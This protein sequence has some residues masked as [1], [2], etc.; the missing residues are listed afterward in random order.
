MDIVKG[1]GNIKGEIGMSILEKLVDFYYVSI[2]GQHKHNYTKL[3]EEGYLPKDQKVGGLPTSWK[4]Y[5]CTD[6][7][8]SI[9]VYDR[10]KKGIPYYN[11]YE[12]LPSK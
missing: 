7:K 2:R 4:T 11:K 5:R 1:D 12:S 6:C 9:T 3:G 8:K 10:K